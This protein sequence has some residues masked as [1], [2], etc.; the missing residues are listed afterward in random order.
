MD[1]SLRKYLER[2]A[3]EELD[4]IL[5]YVVNNYTYRPEEAVRTIVMILE[6]RERIFGCKNGSVSCKRLKRSAFCGK[7]TLKRY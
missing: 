7:I 5:N 3:T 1:H 2:R 6:E 4:T